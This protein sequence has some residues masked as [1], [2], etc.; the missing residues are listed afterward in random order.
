[1]GQMNGCEREDRGPDPLEK[2][3]FRGLLYALV[4]GG[5]LILMGLAKAV[6]RK[7]ARQTQ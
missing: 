4:V 3:R 7:A 2:L 5:G 1:M 6:V